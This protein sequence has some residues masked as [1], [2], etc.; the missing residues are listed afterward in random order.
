MVANAPARLPGLRETKK[1]R[2]RLAIS[3]IATEL[4]ADRGFEH[5]T[6]AEIAAAADV[7]VKTV[8]NY[9][10]AKEDLFFDRAG[11]LISV[12]TMTALERPVDMTIAEAFRQL[13]ADNRIPFPGSGWKALNDP[14]VYEQQRRFIATEQ[15]SPALRARR[16]E[17]ADAW[18][19]PLTAAIATPLG[20]RAPDPRAAIY[21]AMI[22]ALMA[23]RHRVL[24]DAF[25]EHRSAR[26]VERHVRATVNE[27]AARIGRAFADID[28]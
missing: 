11:E 19:T 13:L 22:L 24:S 20:L 25:L 12:L 26:T 9:F 16:L 10:P 5:V 18:H 6:V 8:F 23:Q 27:A 1:A 21:A 28:G 17:I 15:A 3:D 7:S 4:F 14:V 2:T